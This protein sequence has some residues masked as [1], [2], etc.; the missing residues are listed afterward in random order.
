KEIH[1]VG[2]GPIHAGVIEPGHFRFMCLGE[3][4]QHL[5]IRL[6]YQHRGVLNM[7]R[8]K[9]PLELRH[10]I[11][12]IAGDSSVAHTWAYCQG[13]ERLSGVEVTEATELARGIGLELERVA[14]H[15]ATLAG[16]ATDLA[17]GMGSATF[18]R[19]RT[20]II[21]LIMRVCGSRF[22]RSWIQP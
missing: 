1:E 14:M 19:L 12:V 8:G 21:N 10:L 11:E 13:V 5:E 7:L 18:G 9:N 2:V 20:T 6:G 4:I 22:A 16:L 3:V 15:L 17:H